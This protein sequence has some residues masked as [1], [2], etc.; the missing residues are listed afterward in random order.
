MKTLK[1]IPKDK[2]RSPL[3]LWPTP[4]LLR[5]LGFP[6]WRLKGVI[7]GFEENWVY[8]TDAEYYGLFDRWPR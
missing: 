2:L 8:V 1:D 7:Y 3:P 4:R 5:F 6:V